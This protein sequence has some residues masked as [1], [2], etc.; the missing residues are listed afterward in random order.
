LQG[1]TSIYFEE[2]QLSPSLIGL[3]PLLTS[4]P[5][6]FQPTPVR[7]SIWFHPDFILL[8]S[9]SLGFG[10]T[11]YYYAPFSDSLSLR[12]RSF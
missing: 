2:Y 8:M 10:S 12:L 11:P 6:S 7:T 1:Y 9:R 5:S 3:S 4:H